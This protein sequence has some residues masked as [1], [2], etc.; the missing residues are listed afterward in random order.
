M[1]LEVEIMNAWYHEDSDKKLKKVNEQKLPGRTVANSQFSMTDND[2]ASSTISSRHELPKSKP[3][4]MNLENH[5][6]I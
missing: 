6:F 5:L 1:F 2:D 4:K 3:K